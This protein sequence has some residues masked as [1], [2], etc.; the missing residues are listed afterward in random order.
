MHPQKRNKPQWPT[1]LKSCLLGTSII[2]K[3]TGSWQRASGSAQRCCMTD[4][5]AKRRLPS[6]LRSPLV[7]QRR[8]IVAW[9]PVFTKLW[10][11]G[12]ARGEAL[13]LWNHFAGD[14]ERKHFF[15]LMSLASDIYYVA[16]ACS[17][18]TIK[19]ASLLLRSIQSDFA[20]GPKAGPFGLEP[21][22]PPG[23]LLHL[24]PPRRHLR[25]PLPHPQVDNPVAQL[26]NLSNEFSGLH[27][28]K[29]PSTSHS[30]TTGEMERILKVIVLCDK[31]NKNFWISKYIKT[32][33]VLSVKKK[34]RYMY[35]KK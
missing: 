1:K 20:D 28:P 11:L 23:T 3:R 5:Q 17:D 24:P 29:M 25:R 4:G 9:K 15:I 14:W 21:D 27:W 8:M 31:P 13:S 33:T 12:K 16:C 6:S 10:D 35:F 26:W 2:G 18:C 34:L 7:G 19:P 22:S 30:M 32:R